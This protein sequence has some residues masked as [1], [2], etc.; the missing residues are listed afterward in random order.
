[1]TRLLLA[2]L[3]SIALLPSRAEAQCAGSCS[4]DN[5]AMSPRNSG[6]GSQA[7]DG[8]QRSATEERRVGDNGGSVACHVCCAMPTSFDLGRAERGRTGGSATDSGGFRLM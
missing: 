5:T 1:M 6:I 2:A 8:R 3:F 4:T 7:R